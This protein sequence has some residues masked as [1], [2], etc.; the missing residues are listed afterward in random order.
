MTVFSDFQRIPS[1][2]CRY[3]PVSPVSA[4]WGAVEICVYFLSDVV[5]PVLSQMV[6]WV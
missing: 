6:T 4:A 3:F 5:G 2:P 1:D